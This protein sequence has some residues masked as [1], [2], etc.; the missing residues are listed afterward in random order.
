MIRWDSISSNL[1]KIVE[2][3]SMATFETQLN[4]KNVCFL[5]RDWKV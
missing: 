2:G 4:G 1:A 3:L 5:Q